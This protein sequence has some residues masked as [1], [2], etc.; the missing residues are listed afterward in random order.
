MLLARLLRLLLSGRSRRR[1][2]RG[3]TSGE[4][5]RIAQLRFPVLLIHD[6]TSVHAYAGADDLTHMHVNRVVLG[7]AAPILIDSD[8]NV[9]RLDRLRSTHGNLWLLAH[10]GG[11][12]SAT[13]E[14]TP[15]ARRGID[16]ARELLLGCKYLDADPDVDARK[17]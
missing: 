15:L 11:T 16:A 9:Y 1:S 7:K 8:L 17:R 6:G 14:L 10:P 4:T 2:G 5:P 12:T 3:R 13:F